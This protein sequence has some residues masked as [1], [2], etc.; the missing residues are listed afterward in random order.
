[1]TNRFDYIEYNERS[2]KL[3]DERKRVSQDYETLI[4]ELPNS[5][6]KSIALTKLEECFM[7]VGKAIRNIQVNEINYNDKVMVVDP[8]GEYHGTTGV[9][10]DDDDNGENCIVY[11]DGETIGAEGAIYIVIPRNKLVKHG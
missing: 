3:S 9:Y 7:W 1:M 5:R 8:G 6:E 11:P 10:D 4:E 2:Q